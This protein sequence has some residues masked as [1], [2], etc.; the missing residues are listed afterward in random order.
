MKAVYFNRRHGQ[1][2]LGILIMQ[3]I[4]VIPILLVIGFMSSG[5][6]DIASSLQNMAISA[7]MLLGFL[8]IFG[9]YILE[10]F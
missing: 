7:V 8:W 2:S 5:A 9:K 1:R 4:A 3:D 6:N 10:P